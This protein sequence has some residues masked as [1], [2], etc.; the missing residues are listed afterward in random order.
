[1]KS[2]DV[3]SLTKERWLFAHYLLALQPNIVRC[4]KDLSFFQCSLHLFFARAP[5]RDPEI[6]S[7]LIKNWS[8]S[9][10]KK[11]KSWHLVSRKKKKKKVFKRVFPCE[12]YLAWLSV[13]RGCFEAASHASYISF[14]LT[15]EGGFQSFSLHGVEKMS[16]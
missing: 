15:N 6:L 13:S 8:W 12:T 1:M 10:D 5:A 16:R 2:D 4:F 11:V 7:S 9:R 14:S 3:D